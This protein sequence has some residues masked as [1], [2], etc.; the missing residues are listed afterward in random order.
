[1]EVG[2][3]ARS[4]EYNVGEVWEETEFWIDLSWRIDPDGSLGIRGFFE[5]D[6]HPGAPMG[7]DE[8]YGRMFADGV[9][10]LAEAAA[11]AGQSPLEFMRDRGAFAVPGDPYR[12]YERA[13][14]PSAVEGCAKDAHGVF[15]KPGTEGTWDGSPESLEG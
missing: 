12:P 3:D 5:S 1:E 8:Y 4:H 14:D 9:P 2:P 15:R 10:G 6:E 7:V 11:E 13:V